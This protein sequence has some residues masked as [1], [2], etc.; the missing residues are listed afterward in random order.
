MN[1]F[2]CSNSILV[3][4]EDENQ[5]NNLPNQCVPLILDT[6]KYMPTQLDNSTGHP[7]YIVFVDYSS[8]SDE[9]LPLLKKAIQNRLL[10]STNTLFVIYNHTDYP[11]NIFNSNDPTVGD[12]EQSYITSP[13]LYINV[14]NF[15]FQGMNP[16]T[17]RLQLK[18]LKTVLADKD[19]TESA[20]QYLETEL[21][22]LLAA[23][24]LSQA[25]GCLMRKWKPLSKINMIENIM[26]QILKV[27]SDQILGILSN[28]I[29]TLRKLHETPII[30]IIY[31]EATQHTMRSHTFHAESIDSWLNTSKVNAKKEITTQLLK[32]AITALSLRGRQWL[33]ETN[34]SSFCKNQK[35]ENAVSNTQDIV[36]TFKQ[37]KEDWRE[38][39][40]F[41][42]F[43]ARIQFYHEASSSRAWRK[44]I[45]REVSS[46]VS[47]ILPPISSF[48]YETKFE[49]KKGESKAVLNSNIEEIKTLFQADH[50]GFLDGLP[51]FDIPLHH[52]RFTQPGVQLYSG[53]YSILN[54]ATQ[55]RTGLLYPH[56]E[57]VLMSSYT[58]KTCTAYKDSEGEI[59]TLMPILSVALF[60]DKLSGKLYLF[61]F[62]NRRLT[63][64]Y[65]G[66]PPSFKIRVKIPNFNSGIRPKQI[67]EQAFKM[68]PL[69]NGENVGKVV[70]LVA[71]AGEM[72]PYF[73]HL[74]DINKAGMYVDGRLHL[75]EESEMPLLTAFDWFTDTED[76]YELFK[77]DNILFL[78]QFVKDRR[79]TTSLHDPL[80]AL[81]LTVIFSAI[82]GL[83]SH[84]VLSDTFPS[85]NLILLEQFVRTYFYTKRGE[86]LVWD[87]TKS[88]ACILA[89]IGNYKHVFYPRGRSRSRDD[90]HIPRFTHK[91]AR[92]LSPTSRTKNTHKR[93][94][95][96]S[97]S[98]R[99]N[100]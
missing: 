3:C 73:T 49:K 82:C 47:S 19:D 56:G 10:Q 92:S 41:N 30:K 35:T 42:E 24:P 26:I 79:T 28:H 96:R 33:L 85:H 32:I 64:Y 44:M 78:E 76:I 87:S 15:K 95:Y 51:V 54:D 66:C 69:G 60:T 99:R 29:K 97:E 7:P 77:P 17:R 11:I 65:L 94:Q 6:L 55:L 14:Y 36:E 86:P 12:D 38:L 34:L 20:L 23:M 46:W 61:S 90:A 27:N 39:M 21:T 58:D 25:I 53:E 93:K 71:T 31:C 13:F 88:F 8:F 80:A 4:C 16:K 67:R 2:S 89:E 50:K 57:T 74:H 100:N 45:P 48:I 1:D 91:K 83:F 52:I 68:C 40:Q 75:S 98:P 72:A 37:Q 81:N 18:A 5:Y 84:R 22:P 59:H 70:R 9:T 62:D 43:S 63:K